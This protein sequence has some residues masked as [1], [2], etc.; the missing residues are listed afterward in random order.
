[1][2][3][4]RSRGN[5]RNRCDQDALELTGVDGNAFNILGLCQRA[6]KRAGWSQER[7]VAVR[8]EMMVGNYDH[9]LATACEH[10]EV[11]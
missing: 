1:M 7:W 3:D 9:L 4:A 6:A 10:F 11:R 2:R 8:D 5:L